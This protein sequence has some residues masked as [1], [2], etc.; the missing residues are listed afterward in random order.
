[1]LLHFANPLKSEEDEAT[2]ARLCKG[3]SVGLA[4]GSDA[5]LAALEA[6]VRRMLH[7]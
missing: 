6:E 7:G 1:M 5:F 4:V 2:T 3:E